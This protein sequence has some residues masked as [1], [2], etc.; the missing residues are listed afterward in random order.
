MHIQVVNFNLKDMTEAEFVRACDEQFAPAFSNITGLISKMWLS[1]PATNTYGGV[2]TWEDRDAM[3]RYQE[4][5][6][7]KSVVSSHHFANITARDYSLME[8]PSSVTNGIPALPAS[9]GA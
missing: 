3:L 7:F 1:D 4:T 8:G 9:L 6:L 5:E 2:Y